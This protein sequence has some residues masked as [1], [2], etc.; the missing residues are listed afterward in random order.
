MSSGGGDN[1]YNA[2]AVQSGTSLMTDSGGS[3]WLHAN[4]FYEGF[5]YLILFFNLDLLEYV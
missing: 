5:M 2:T 4:L 3:A 1:P